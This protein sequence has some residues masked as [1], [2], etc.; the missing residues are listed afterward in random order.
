MG[1]YWSRITHVANG[2]T[3]DIWARV[4]TDNT[5]SDDVQKIINHQTNLLEING[6]KNEGADDIFRLSGF[7]KIE[8]GSCCGFYTDANLKS[9]VYVSVVTSSGVMTCQ[10]YSVQVNRSV[11]IDKEGYVKEA[12]Y[13]IGPFGKSSIWIDKFGKDHRLY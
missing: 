2:T 1:P 5:K 6:T 4:D 12:M 3:G 7:T 13:A 11:I 8:S 10:H 9:S